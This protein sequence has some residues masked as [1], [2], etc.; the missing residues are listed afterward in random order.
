MSWLVSLWKIPLSY[1][2]WLHSNDDEDDEIDEK[3]AKET[4]DEQNK[5]ESNETNM[6][7]K[8]VK[9]IHTSMNT[10]LDDLAL[11]LTKQMDESRKRIHDVFDIQYTLGSVMQPND[12]ETNRK[13]LEFEINVLQTSMENQI[14]YSTKRLK[15]YLEPMIPIPLSETIPSET[16][17]GLGKEHQVEENAKTFSSSP[18]L[19]N[20]G[21][22]DKMKRRI[23]HWSNVILT[24]IRASQE[25]AGPSFQELSREVGLHETQVR[26]IC[27]L[28]LEKHFIYTTLENHVKSCT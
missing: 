20:H 16:N 25:D 28:L 8:C 22:E 1:V 26:R 17:V 14:Q 19:T 9:E 21:Y 7:I 18:S 27:D 12:L 15:E 13:T 4:N 5:D 11:V 23:D 3:M 10:E 6:E 2:E 24:H